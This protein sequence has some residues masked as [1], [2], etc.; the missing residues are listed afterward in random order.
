MSLTVGEQKKLD[1]LYW[2]EDFY[3]SN[4]RIVQ[5]FDLPI[6]NRGQASGQLW[7]F[8]TP[9]LTGKVCSTC[10]TEMI[11]HCRSAR[12]QK[13]PRCPN[14]CDVKQKKTEKKLKKRRR[15]RAKELSGICVTI[16]EEQFEKLEKEGTVKEIKWAIWEFLLE[17]GERDIEFENFVNTLKNNE[18]S[19]P[20]S[21]PPITLEIIEKKKL[22][23]MIGA[24]ETC[25]A[26]HKFRSRLEARWA[27]VFDY[28][29]IEWVYE[30]Q[31]YTNGALSYLPDFWLPEPGWWIETKGKELDSNEKEKAKML[32]ELTEHPVFC[33]IG[34]PNDWS[35]VYV[36]NDI[37]GDVFESYLDKDG[38]LE[39]ALLAGSQA[40]FEWGET[41]TTV[42]EFKSSSEFLESLIQWRVSGYVSGLEEGEIMSVIVFLLRVTMELVRQ[43]AKDEAL[44]EYWENTIFLLHHLTESCI[45]R[46]KECLETKKGFD[47]AVDQSGFQ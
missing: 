3:V 29:G 12:D 32:F 2:N 1:E 15:Q 19:V 28:L 10:G 41:P 9:Y 30:P 4:W 31:T 24:V 43:T 40:R 37:S 33:L 14:D 8:V 11:Y 6:E 26:K 5:Q 34:Y 16:P 36:S 22:V 46:A 13:K 18:R 27:V 38:R 20:E 45:E 17:N 35:A 47:N 44:R 21:E 42:S 7:R 25:Y 23:P 39:K